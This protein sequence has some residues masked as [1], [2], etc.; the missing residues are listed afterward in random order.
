MKKVSKALKETGGAATEYQQVVIELEGLKKVLQQLEAFEPTEDN[1][2]HVNAIRGMALACQL[3]LR[4]FMVKLEKYEASLGP[5]ADRK[6][7]RGVGRKARWATAFSADVE[8]LR[9]MVA[10]KNTSINLLLAMHSSQSLSRIEVRGK[11][12]HTYLMTKVAEHRAAL[13]QVQH[14]LINIEENMTNADHV[15]N[16]RLNAISDK[17]GETQQSVLSLRG[18]GEQISALLRSF[19]LEMRDLLQGI[20]QSNWHIYQ[21]LLQIQHNPPKSPTGLLDSNIKF[22]DAMGDRRELPYDIFRH[23]EPFEGY[24]RAQ[25]KD[26]LGENKILEG[27]FHIVNVKDRNAI[28]K[29]EHWTRSIH[30]G[31]TLAMSMVMSHL[32]RQ[33]GTCPRLSCPGV[34]LVIDS[35]SSV[36]ACDSCGLNFY[37]KEDDLEEKL[38]Q[39]TILDEED[40]IARQQA[41]EDL[42]LYGSRFKPTDIAGVDEDIQFPRPKR[43]ASGFEAVVN[44]P[45]KIRKDSSEEDYKG[46]AVTA[47]DWNAGESPLSAWLNQSAIPSVVPA[48]NVF[49]DQTAGTLGLD[50]IEREVKEIEVFRNVHMATAPEPAHQIAAS[51]QDNILNLELGAQIYYRNIVNRYPLLPVYLARR[52]AIANKDWAERLQRQRLKTQ[53]KHGNS[54]DATALDPMVSQNLSKFSDAGPLSEI[55]PADL[56]GPLLSSPSAA[57]RPAAVA[58]AD[59]VGQRATSTPPKDSEG[60]YPCPFCTKTY[61]VK[62]DLKRHLVDLRKHFQSC[63]IRKSTLFGGYHISPCTTN[64]N[65]L[66]SLDRTI[67]ELCQDELYQPYPDTSRAKKAAASV[68]KHPLI[69]QNRHRKGSMDNE[70]SRVP[71]RIQSPLQSPWI[72]RPMET[73]SA[74]H[75]NGFPTTPLDTQS[76]FWTGRNSSPRPGSVHSRSSSMNCSLHGSAQSDPEEQNPSFGTFHERSGSADFGSSS[77]GH[78]PPPVMLLSMKDQSN[79]DVSS[80]TQNIERMFCLKLFNRL[81]SLTAHM[82]SHVGEKPYACLVE[83]CGRHFSDPSNLRRHSKVHQS[84]DDSNEKSFA[85]QVEKLTTPLKHLSSQ[86]SDTEGPANFNNTEHCFVCDICGE[87]VRVHRRLEWQ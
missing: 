70:R 80:G 5:F 28:L 32:Q 85:I 45:A 69:P 67:A 3:P 30:Q 57:E 21:I 13:E 2:R 7:F 62:K 41:E 40:R 42:R 73:R 24:L 52:L 82:Y 4:D 78:P 84:D 43:T 74:A 86:S 38:S 58:G 48:V 66:P 15:Y 71:E 59:I 61:L 76:D 81:S 44:R 68:F 29:K 12:E 17:V 46:G 36:L 56:T 19:L 63:D 23:W 75:T 51:T 14:H 26:K 27:K 64:P 83:G 72:S 50:P 34:G 55:P 35:S 37:P 49:Q 22:E 1:A 60:K 16:A 77:R 79:N 18:I 9:A 33:S 10:A 20:L 31:A 6:S 87:T 54:Q 39:A 25:F 53:A 65:D 8:K 11:K 47:M